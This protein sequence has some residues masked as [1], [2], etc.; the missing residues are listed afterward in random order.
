MK[1]PYVAL[2]S[3]VSAISLCGPAAAAVLM[4]PRQQ[5]LFTLKMA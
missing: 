1:V 5:G 3:A 2:A 4:S